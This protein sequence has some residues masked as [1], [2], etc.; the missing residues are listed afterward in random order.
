M[1]PAQ[2]IGS[3]HTEALIHFSLRLFPLIITTADSRVGPWFPSGQHPTCFGEEFRGTKRGFEIGQP[4][5]KEY[6][7]LTLDSEP[8]SNLELGMR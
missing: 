2:A 7:C 4:S 5:R 6:L 8:G 3:H 1:E